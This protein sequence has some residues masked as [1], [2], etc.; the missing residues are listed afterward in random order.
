MRILVISDIHA[1]AAALEAVLSQADPHDAVWC[2]GDLVGYGP[3]PNECVA[4]VRELPNLTCLAGNHDKAVL[5]EI[6][7]DTFNDDARAVILW[8]RNALSA[9]HL[10]YLREL[11]VE[12]THGDFTLVHGSPRQP[13]WEYILNRTIACD[14]FPYIET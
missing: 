5:G 1:N 11:P 12:L 7:P 3:D 9:E 8:T 2:L 4:R 14:N 13:V 10:E 6:D